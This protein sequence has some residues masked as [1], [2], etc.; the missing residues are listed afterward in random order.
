LLAIRVSTQYVNAAWKT[1][2]GDF[3]M[4]NLVFVLALGVSLPTFASAR[5]LVAIDCEGHHRYGGSMYFHAKTVLVDKEKKSARLIDATALFKEDTNAKEQYGRA[6]NLFSD[7]AYRPT[8]YKKHLRFDLNKMVNP[9]DFSHYYPDGCST[10]LLLPNDVVSS[11]KSRA[12][13]P[14]VMSCEQGGA[15]VVMDC[16]V[17]TVR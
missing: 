8:K 16:K 13:V 9:S 3:P 2:F 1:F 6:K 14:V 15:T 17:E 4:K 10:S 7:P 5:D 11:N 12:E